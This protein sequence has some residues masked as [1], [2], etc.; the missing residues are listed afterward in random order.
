M[1]D[2][3]Y[4]NDSIVSSETLL[5]YVDEQHEFIRKIV[6]SDIAAKGR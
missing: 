2:S 3:Y 5:I 4:Y 1:P 6:Y